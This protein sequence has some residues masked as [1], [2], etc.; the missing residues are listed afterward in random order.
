MEKLITLPPGGSLHHPKVR[1]TVL[2][3]TMA[4]RQEELGLNENGYSEEGFIN[5]LKLSFG[6]KTED[7]VE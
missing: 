5:F 4:P 7:I 2:R 1:S 3:L 6:Q